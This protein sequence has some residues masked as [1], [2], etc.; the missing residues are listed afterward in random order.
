MKFALFILSKTLQEI[1]VAVKYL[2]ILAVMAG[3]DAVSPLALK[4]SLERTLN[5]NEGI[6]WAL[7]I[8]AIIRWLKQTS[9]HP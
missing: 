7:R 3:N 8:S 9:G 5:I 2:P 1:G 4:D 6:D